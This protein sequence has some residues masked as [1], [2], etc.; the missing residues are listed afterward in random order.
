M[1]AP[2]R[3]LSALLRGTYCIFEVLLTLPFTLSLPNETGWHHV[4][5][6][7]VVGGACFKQ[8]H[9]LY[10]IMHRGGGVNLYSFDNSSGGKVMD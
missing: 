6:S 2:K 1:V 4:P 9:S 7:Y 5:V 10:S 3:R 8:K